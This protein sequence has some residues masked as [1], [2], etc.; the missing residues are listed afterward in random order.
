MSD[1]ELVTALRRISATRRAADARDIA[2]KALAVY[3]TKRKRA[4]LLRRLEGLPSAKPFV[5]HRRGADETPAQIQERLYRE[6][7]QA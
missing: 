6:S 5:S 7:K 1:S 3:E 2:D 4:D